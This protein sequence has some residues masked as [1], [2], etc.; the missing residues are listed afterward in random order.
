MQR[1]SLRRQR[2]E[3]DVFV[4]LGDIN[5]LLAFELQGVRNVLVYPHG[6]DDRASTR[7]IRDVSQYSHG[8]F[9]SNPEYLS[10]IA[11]TSARSALI[12]L[13]VHNLTWLV[14]NYTTARS[15]GGSP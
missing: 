8:S 7:R 6:S 11:G 12:C 13:S 2:S 5:D 9:R 4:L 15:G 10:V 3:S 1:V 14:G